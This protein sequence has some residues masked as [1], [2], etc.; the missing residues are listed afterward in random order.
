MCLVMVINHSRARVPFLQ[1][2]LREIRYLE[3]MG[4]FQLSA[5]HISGVDNRISDYLSRWDDSK[6]YP[7]KFRHATRGYSLVEHTVHNDL[8]EFS[9][10]W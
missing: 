9:H 6:E 2:C 3:A 5:V 7:R 4:S 8:F 10:T 1:A